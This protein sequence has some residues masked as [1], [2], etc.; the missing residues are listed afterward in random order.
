MTENELQHHGIFGMHWGIRRFQNK[1]GSLTPAGKKRYGVGESTSSSNNTKTSSNNSNAGQSSQP[2]KTSSNNSNTEQSSQPA[3]TSESITQ[4]SSRPKPVSEM[5]N[6]EIQDF[7]NRVDL[8]KKYNAIVNPPPAPKEKSAISKIISSA[9]NDSLKEVA[10]LVIAGALKSAL[11]LNKNDNNNSDGG[12]KN[13]KS[14][15]NQEGDTNKAK[16]KNKTKEKSKAAQALDTLLADKIAG[17]GS[18]KKSE[19]SNESLITKAMDLAYGKKKT[20]PKQTWTSDAGYS[21]TDISF[22]DLWDSVSGG[23]SSATN[24]AADLV[25]GYIDWSYDT[26]G[27]TVD[28]DWWK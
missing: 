13:K 9:W 4:V 11:G 14:N 26:I 23:S 21:V 22:R 7:L 10:K 20:K 5:S 27:T 16:T 28:Y 17:F 3:K 25:N 24:K 18:S 2:A 6:K 12:G 19:E 8:E 1:D 15:E